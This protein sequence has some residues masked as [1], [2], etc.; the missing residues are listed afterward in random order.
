MTRLEGMPISPGYAKGIAVVYDYE[1]ECR[2]ELP[3]RSI[4]HLEVGSEYG[5]LD[6]ALE[7]SSHDLKSLE[8]SALHEPMLVDAAALLSA[9][10]A[11]AKEIAEI[12]RQ[13]IRRELVNA[14]E[15]LDAVIREFVVRFGRLDSTYF[16]ER[17]QDVRDVGRRMMGHL[18]SL[19]Q[20]MRL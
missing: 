18:S 2:L 14:E 19:P 9:H 7:R 4:S 5:R 6:D 11:M 3:S 10:S 1:I 13:R 8:Q 20:F 16:R 17:Q 15:A 12:V